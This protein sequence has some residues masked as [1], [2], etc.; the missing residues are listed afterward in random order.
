VTSNTYTTILTKEENSNM[1][2]FKIK[3]FSLHQHMQK[4]T[5]VKNKPKSSFF[6]APNRHLQRLVKAFRSNS[7]RIPY[8]EAS[9]KH[10]RKQVNATNEMCQARTTQPPGHELTVE[11]RASETTLGSPWITHFYRRSQD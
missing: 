3:C 5:N 7:G 9:T 10:C 6:P 4:Y 1:M 8:T 11:A 2:K